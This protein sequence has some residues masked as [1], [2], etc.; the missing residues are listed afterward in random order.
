MSSSASYPIFRHRHRPESRTWR[1]AGRC[2]CSATCWWSGMLR[3]CCCLKNCRHY[4][5]AFCSSFCRWRPQTT[6]LFSRFSVFRSRQG[7]PLCCLHANPSVLGE[8]QHFRVTE[9][10]KQWRRGEGNEKE[11]SRFSFCFLD[12]K[13]LWNFDC[14]CS[15]DWISTSLHNC[16]E[17]LPK[18][19]IFL[20]I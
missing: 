3:R 8:S 13:G 7:D 12:S 4:L 5:R 20:G 15:H 10:R 14:S 11:N 19:S 1:R 16:L 9:G 2:G 6:F 17:K 18:K